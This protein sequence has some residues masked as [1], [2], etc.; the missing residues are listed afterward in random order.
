MDI[1]AQIFTLE[2]IKGRQKTANFVNDYVLKF[3]LKYFN[4]FSLW[5]SKFF[6]NKARWQALRYVIEVC[7]LEINLLN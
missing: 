4:I 7:N 5:L 1:Y 2:S 6:K 3:E